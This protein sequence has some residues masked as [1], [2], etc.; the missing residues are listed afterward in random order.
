[1]KKNGSLTSVRMV[2]LVVLFL[3]LTVFANQTWA[4]F[5]SPKKAR[6]VGKAGVTFQKAGD[7]FDPAAGPIYY[8]VS[9]DDSSRI[10]I[11]TPK[12]APIEI[13][14]LDETAKKTLAQAVVTD[15]TRSISYGPLS[16]NKPYFIK[17]SGK[18]KT[19]F[20]ISFKKEPIPATK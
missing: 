9:V 2:S 15:T 7:L 11:E 16:K 1:M 3:G 6:N 4:A 20:Q 17:I 5:N 8:R 19:S 14:L 13:E 12:G 10:I 18:E